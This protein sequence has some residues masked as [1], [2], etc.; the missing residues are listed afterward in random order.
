[1]DI[2]LLCNLSVDNYLTIIAIIIDI[3]L[4]L[5]VFY[6]TFKLH[7]KDEEVQKL[8][9][10]QQTYYEEQ[11]F[12]IN[13]RPYLEETG[14]IVIKI[15]L[16]LEHYL[17]IYDYK[18]LKNFNTYKQ[19]TQYIN[20]KYNDVLELSNLLIFKSKYLPDKP[21]K[22]LEKL[23]REF[24]NLNDTI[25]KFLFPDDIITDEERNNLVSYE[26]IKYI[27]QKSEELIKLSQYLVDIIKKNIN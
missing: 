12:N 1:M 15:Q 9:T 21:S 25:S 6:Q 24:R 17:L 23:R 11:N 4:T 5:I 18:Y 27:N 8:I 3:I 22:E 2:K 19:I 14:I 20:S 13:C 16:V 10:K 26:N 7:K